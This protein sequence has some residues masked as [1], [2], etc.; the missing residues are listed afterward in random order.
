[1]H[2]SARLFVETA[3]YGYTAVSVATEHPWWVEGYNPADPR[4]RPEGPSD[5]T[6]MARDLRRRQVAYL[7]LPEGRSSTVAPWATLVRR[8][9]PFEIFRTQWSVAPE[10]SDPARD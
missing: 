4:N 6:R 2:D 3:G 8:S 1:L 5:A 10:N 9:G 7:A